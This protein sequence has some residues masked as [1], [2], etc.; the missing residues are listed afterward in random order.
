MKAFEQLRHVVPVVR[1]FYGIAWRHQPSYPFLIAANI[2]LTGLA[3]FVNIVMPKFIIDELL[4]ARRAHVLAYLVLAVVGANFAIY[5]LNNLRDYAF[6]RAHHS[7]DLKLNEIVGEQS[8]AMDFEHTEDPEVLNQLEKAKVGVSWYSGGIAGLTNNITTIVSGLIQLAGTLYIIMILSPWLIVL[9]LAVTVASMVVTAHNQR[10][11]VQFM[12][13]LVGIN[14]RAGYYFS[15]LKDVRYGKDARLY[16]AANLFVSTIDRLIDEVWSIEMKR[17]R[18]WNR[19]AVVLTSFNAVQQGV[20]FGYLG[21]QAL[22]GL[23]TI[24]ELQMLVSSAT[25]F[26]QSLSSV[27]EQVIDLGKN[28]D[29]M[30]EYKR[31]M[32]YPR[33]KEWGTQALPLQPRHSLELRNVSFR[34]PRSNQDAL[35]NVSLVIPAGQKLAIVGENGAGKTTMVKLLTRLYDPTEGSILVDGQDARR[36]ALDEYAKLFAVVFQDFKLLAFSLRENVA[37]GKGD[38]GRSDEILRRTLDKV[39]LAERAIALPR[40]LDTPVY[41]AF[42]E[43]GVELS[44]GEQQRLAIARAVFKDAPV[45]ILDEPTAALD[46]VAEYEVYR[47]FDRLVGDKTAIYISHRLSSCQ[48]C[49]KIAVFDHGEIVEYGAHDELLALGGKYAQMWHAQAQW[50]VDG[51]PGAAGS[52]PGSA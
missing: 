26:S 46:P 48:F 12:K 1:Y 33:A 25:A 21:L 47:H 40:G 17:T 20:L 41:K 24:G 22:A 52:L 15:F 42:D 6:S 4:G 31:F 28:A 51:E 45:V 23:I 49:D 36:F 16:N 39:G 8:M 50:Y 43:D 38:A 44:G 5:L 35:R 27:L 18:V 34:Y 30:N 3:P 14:R 10:A 11:H 32:E 19:Y 29:F 13:D 9:I 7:F 2:L 37:I